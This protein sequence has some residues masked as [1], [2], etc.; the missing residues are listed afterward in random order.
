[1]APFLTLIPA[2][3]SPWACLFLS[4]VTVDSF[5]EQLVSGVQETAGHHTD[6]GGSVTSLDILRLA[7]LDQHPGSG[8]DHV[9]L[10]EDGSP[11]VGDGHL[12]LGVLDHLVHAPRTQTGP[13]GVGQSLGRLDITLPDLLR[14]G[15]FGSH[16]TL[17]SLTTS[18]GCSCGRHDEA[19]TSVS[20]CKENRDDKLLLTEDQNSVTDRSD[21]PMYSAL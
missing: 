15:V 7:E 5:L 3:F 12:T 8:V 20:L 13:D 2:V 14:L 6:G 16:Q 4:S 11:V 18:P 17:S 10:I 19:A 21:L 1:M 9:H